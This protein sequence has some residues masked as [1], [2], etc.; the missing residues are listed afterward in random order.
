MR[1]T[2]LLWSVVLALVG[3][4]L[5]CGGVGLGNE[6]SPPKKIL[7][8]A[9]RAAEAVDQVEATLEVTGHLKVADA[10]D[11]GGGKAT[12]LK[13][14]AV[15][16]LS[17][18]EKRLSASKSGTA[19]L[20]SVRY[21]DK[22]T[23]A[24]RVGEEEFKPALR[25]ERR[26]IAVEV[27]LPKITSFSPRGALTR[28]EL[29]L[30]D[31][32]GNSL[33]LDR[34]L[35]E[36]SM[37]A[38]ESWK[39]PEA[40]VAALVGL[41]KVT[42]SDATS[43][44]TEMTE[45]GAKIEMTG[46][47][48]GSAGG[49]ASQIELKAKYRFNVKAGRIDWFGLLVKED[50]KPGPVGPGLDVVA[51][52]QM[53]IASR[54]ASAELAQEALAGLT[55]GPTEELCRVECR[56]PGGVWQLDHDRRWVVVNEHEE[57]TVLRMVDKGDYLAQCNVV[58]A[59]QAAPQQA[60]SLSDFQ[61]EIRSVLDKNF[62]QFVRAEEFSGENEEQIYRVEADGEVSEVPIRWIHYRIADGQGRRVVVAF[63]IKEELLERFEEHDKDVIHGLG[64]LQPKVAAAKAEG[65][66]GGAG[67]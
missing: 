48:E 62:A 17:Y 14:G 18:A 1:P 13:M 39:H 9:K 46:R 30:V 6:D 56:S 67:R 51:R 42:Q 5:V 49:L 47:V 4:A 16:T 21:Y 22:A 29:D 40:V 28:E 24:I 64:F 55:L 26:L 35:P 25:E 33:L 38:G 23:A 3:G 7:L 20:R 31:L 19:P 2:W 27:A 41:D 66:R 11:P 53:T 54:Q 59:R 58:A 15:A 37:A 61:D 52:L 45:T 44:L 65:Q 12:P 50:R 36:K 43:V 8:V 63:T 32:L 57:S 10:A 60:P 34:L